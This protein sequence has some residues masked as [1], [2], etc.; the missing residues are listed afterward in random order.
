MDKN[1]SD[2]GS[3]P[4][5]DL[6]PT[7]RQAVKRVVRDPPPDDVSARALAAARRLGVSHPAAARAVRRHGMVW[8][9]L[10][11]AASIALVAALAWW[12]WRGTPE[13]HVVLQ[14]QKDEP[15]NA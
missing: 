4:A 9:M 11:V 15:G 12:Y 13:E 7:L 5:D 1:R 3:G 2:R 8:R 10:G 6:S 14:P